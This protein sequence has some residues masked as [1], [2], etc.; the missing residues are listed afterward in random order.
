MDE[1]NGV[2]KVD[3]KTARENAGM[4]KELASQIFKEVSF[5]DI[6]IDD[7]EEGNAYLNQQEVDTL[8]GMYGIPDFLRKGAY[9]KYSNKKF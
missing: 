7:V 4:S 1:F 5:S 6:S 9:E 3:F 2:V 8:C